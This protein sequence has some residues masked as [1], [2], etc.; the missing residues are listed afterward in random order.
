M[1]WIDPTK[2]ALTTA[3]TEKIIAPGSRSGITSFKQQSA[4]LLSSGWTKVI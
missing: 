2:F 3:Q 1:V 4:M